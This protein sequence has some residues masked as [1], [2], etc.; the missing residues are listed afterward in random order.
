VGGGVEL[1]RESKTE[2]VL[3]RQEGYKDRKL[4]PGIVNPYTYIQHHR[5]KVDYA[6]YKRLGY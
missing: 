2:E 4:P 5:N 3:G 6:G 1:L